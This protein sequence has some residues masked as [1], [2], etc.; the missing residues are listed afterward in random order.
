MRPISNRRG[1]NQYT[2]PRPQPPT[3]GDLATRLEVEQAAWAFTDPPSD[4]QAVAMAK[5]A[6]RAKSA[7]SQAR[8]AICPDREV[9]ESLAQSGNATEPI[10]RLLAEDLPEVRIH[11]AGNRASPPDVLDRLSRDPIDGIRGAV[12]ANPSTPPDVLDRL[13]EDNW[14]V[15]HAVFCNKSTPDAVRARMQPVYGF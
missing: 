2:R 3:T 11:V 7:A 10:L 13:A 5:T 1:S 15:G 9:R 4:E 14:V 6:K 12:G 8:W